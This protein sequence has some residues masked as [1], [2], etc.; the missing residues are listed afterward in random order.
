MNGYTEGIEEDKL[1]SLAE[2]PVAAKNMFGKNMYFYWILGR[3][4]ANVSSISGHI[5]SES[6][7][8]RRLVKSIAWNFF[9]LDNLITSTSSP[10]GIC[11]LV[12]NQ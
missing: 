9:V 1:L 5:A 2:H 4:L 10:H 3:W 8:V 12:G 6:G 11:H 7:F